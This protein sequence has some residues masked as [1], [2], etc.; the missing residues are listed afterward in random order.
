MEMT[1]ESSITI[2][3]SAQRVTLPL[4]LSGLLVSLGMEGKPVVVELDQVAIFPRD[5]RTT[6]L[7]EGA[8][9]EIV[10]LAAG[11]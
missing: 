1:D 6:L 4:S 2:N 5:F 3:G 10:V 8:R 7:H 11:G 9:V